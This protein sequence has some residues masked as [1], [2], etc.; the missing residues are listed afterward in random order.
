MTYIPHTR[1][2]EQGATALLIVIF[3]VLLF[4]VVSVGFMRTMVQDQQES[5]DSELSQGAYD[6]AL[7]GIEDGK[8]ALALCVQQGNQAA[9]D[10]LDAKECT[11][12]SDAGIVNVTGGETVVKT[13]TASGSAG[14]DYQQAYTCVK[15]S[16]NTADYVGTIG[17]DNSRIIPLRVQSTASFDTIELSWYAPAA[18]QAARVVTLPT[19][20]AAADRRFT[21]L[22]DWGGASPNTRPPV[23]RA[24]LMQFTKDNI[25]LRDFDENANAHTL[26]LYPSTAASP[27]VSFA[28]DGRRTGSQVPVGAPCTTSPAA[29]PVAPIDSYYCHVRIAVP[30]AL[31]SNPSLSN[32]DKLAYLRLTTMYGATDFRIKL[33]KGPDLVEF[34]GVQPT[35]DATGRAGDAFR[36]VLAHVELADP[37]ADANLYPRATVD[38]TDNFCKVLFV[39]NNASDYDDG[40]GVCN[41]LELPPV[42]P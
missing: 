26:Y 12:V 7:A 16:R 1:R 41:A 8:R 20:A 27:T 11:T 22:A 9:C 15:V 25:K 5:A 13:S 31:R 6:S 42:T 10:T 33:Y 19:G 32:T 39:T 23:V 36:R 34:N 37:M 40:T 14:S 3:S 21:T 30:D 18:G 38:L 24:Q 35:I 4:I 28:A 29:S 17:A 2:A